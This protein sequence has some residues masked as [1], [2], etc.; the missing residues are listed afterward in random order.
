VLN[1]LSSILSE[2]QRLGE[3][4]GLPSLA[5]AAARHHHS[6]HSSH[7]DGGSGERG[8][9]EF[10]LQLLLRPQAKV[11]GSQ[12]PAASLHL[13]SRTSMLSHRRIHGSA[14]MLEDSASFISMNEAANWLR[15]NPFS[16]LLTGHFLQLQ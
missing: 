15:F 7:S 13:K 3:A 14:V 16:P 12:L 10:V 4:M 5:K 9:V 2:I 8:V 11:L 6:N 1:L